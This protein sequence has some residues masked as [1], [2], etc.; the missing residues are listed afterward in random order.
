MLTASPISTSAA[1]VSLEPWKLRVPDICRAKWRVKF[2]EA[3]G[4]FRTAV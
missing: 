1:A 2:R 3:G 4:N